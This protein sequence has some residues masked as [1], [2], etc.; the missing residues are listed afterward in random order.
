MSRNIYQRVRENPKFN[1]LVTRRGRLGAL[2][3]LMV[4]GSYYLFVMVV[5]F[6]PDTLRTPLHE[7]GMLTV[8]VPVGAAIIIGSWLLTGYYVHKANSDFDRLSA[9]LVK[10]VSK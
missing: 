7:G 6:S 2:L 8:G 5:A 10:E 3:S 9:D 4:L 1:E